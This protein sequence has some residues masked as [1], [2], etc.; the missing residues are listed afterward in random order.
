MQAAEQSKKY[1]IRRMKDSDISQVLEIDQDAFPTQWPRPTH[2]SFQHELRNKLAHYIVAWYPGRAVSPEKSGNG[3]EPI[4]MQKVISYIRGLFDH[5]R[6]FGPEPPPRERLVGLAGIW[7]MVDEAHIVTIAVRRALQRRGLGEWLLINLIE[8]SAQMKARAMTLEVRKSNTVAQALYE[9]YGFIR[10]GMRTRYYSDN[11]EDAVIM[12]T[13]DL[14]SSS[15][16]ERFN[17][18]KQEHR[19]RRSNCYSELQL[20]TGRN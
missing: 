6:F 15:Y 4:N 18:L 2:S 9:K 19:V 1:Y 8:M 3:H 16:R 20:T 17:H 13:E 10:V 5:D 7:M 12:S 11:G 14:V